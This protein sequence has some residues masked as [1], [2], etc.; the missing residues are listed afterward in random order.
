EYMPEGRCDVAVT[1]NVKDKKIN[2][3]AIIDL[4]DMEF[5]CSQWQFPI[6]GTHGKIEYS[7]DNLYFRDVKGYMVTGMLTNGKKLSTPHFVFDGLVDIT[8]PSCTLTFEMANLLVGEP[9]VRKIPG[10][11][12]RLWETFKPRGR[13]DVRTEYLINGVS[14][15][16]EFYTEINCKEVDILC[17]KLPVPVSNLNG[18]IETDG[19]MV[20]TRELRGRTCNGDVSAVLR[21]DLGSSPIQYKL[22]LNF[23]NADLSEFLKVALNSDKQWSGFISGQSEF[24]CKGNSTEN[25]SGKGEINL[26]E[27]NIFDMPIILSLFKVLNLSLPAKDIF[28]TAHVEYTMGNGVVHIE[29]ANLVSDTVEISGTGDV[30]LDGRIDMM[31]IVVFRDTSFL[32]GIPIIGEIKDFLIGGIVRR[33]TKFEIKGTVM[34][35]KTKPVSLEAFKSPSVK[36][37]FELLR[38]E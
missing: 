12:E 32:G 15:N 36:N 35:P 3:D 10:I 31:A 29:K 23:T 8:A 28:H 19:N 21:L 6:F 14:K 24:Y 25:I 1:C 38:G 7:G 20:Y 5:L 22:K 26:R 13:V 11:G 18:F 4:R 27:G 2:C 9:L 34:D 30:N 17:P 16:P 33:L 37:V